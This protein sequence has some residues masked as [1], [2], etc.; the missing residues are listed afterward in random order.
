MSPS[1]YPNSYSESL[2]GSGSRWADTRNGFFFDDYYMT[3]G[4]ETV[5]ETRSFWVE[6]GLRF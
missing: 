4:A 3:Q 5:R 6:T 2:D 1:Y